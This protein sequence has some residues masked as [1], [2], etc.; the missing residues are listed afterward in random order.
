MA[1]SNLVSQEEAL[2]FLCGYC[3]QDPQECYCFFTAEYDSTAMG[4]SGPEE[5]EMDQYDGGEAA[6]NLDNFDPNDQLVPVM[7]AGYALPSQR[8][9]YPDPFNQEELPDSFYDVFEPLDPQL[10]DATFLLR[11]PSPLPDEVDVQVVPS[12]QATSENHL[13]Y[14]DD[15]L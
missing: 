12:V 5:E 11:P 13:D 2:V 8:F 6:F 9:A 15:F 7:G 10:L 1:A 4:V 14:D 3:L